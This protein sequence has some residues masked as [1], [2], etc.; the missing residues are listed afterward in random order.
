MLLIGRES[1]STC[2]RCARTEAR[3]R[4]QEVG[5]MDYGANEGSSVE[6]PRGQSLEGRRARGKTSKR[7]SQDGRP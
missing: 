6:G 5:G 4:V 7:D 2:A 3:R 1:A